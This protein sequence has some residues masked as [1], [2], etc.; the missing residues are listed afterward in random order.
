MSKVIKII[1]IIFS[2]FTLAACGGS[3]SSNSEPPAPTPTYTLSLTAGEGGSVSDNAGTYEEGTAVTIQATAD[4]GF[5]FIGW[6][7]SS[8]VTTNPLT[9]TVNGDTS[10]TANFARQFA[11]A[12]ATNT[13]GTVTGFDA[14]VAVDG[15]EITLTAT[16][17]EGYRFLR[18]EGSVDT[19]NSTN[20]PLTVTVSADTNLS[21]VFAQEF[22]VALT[23]Q[24]GGTVSG[25]NDTSALTGESITV[26][27]TPETG[28]RFTGWSGTVTSTDNPLAVTVSEDV[29]LTAN[30]VQTFAL[31]VSS[32]AGGSVD[33]LSDRYDVGSS[34]TL[35]A[36][37]DMDYRFDGWT[38]DVTSSENPLTVTVDQNLSVNA[39]FLEGLLGQAGR[40]IEPITQI[41]VAVFIITFPDT[42]DSKLAEFP[43]LTEM[44]TLL[45]DPQGNIV[46]YLDSISYGQF[47]LDF[48]VLGSFEYSENLLDGST[49][50]N[51]DD[52]R[53]MTSIEVAGFEP[54]AYDI[55]YYLLYSDVANLGANA[56][57]GNLANPLVINQQNVVKPSIVG[58]YWINQCYASRATD[59]GFPVSNAATATENYLIQLP[60]NDIEGQV[61]Y[62]MTQFERTT[63][64]EV[65]HAMGLGTHAYSSTNGAST[66]FEPEVADNGTFLNRD[67]GNK[68]DIM[69]TAEY[70]VSLNAGFRDFFGWLQNRKLKVAAP[71]THTVTL[72]PLNSTSGLTAVEVRIPNDF[73]L[74]DEFIANMVNYKNNGL[75]IEVRSTTDIYDVIDESQLSSAGS[76]L[77]INLTDGLTTRLIDAS[78]SANITTSYGQVAADLRDVTLQPGMSFVDASGKITIDNV[79]DNGDGS[80]TFDVTLTD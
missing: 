15:E 45:N 28:Y 8:T 36:T 66:Y 68:F 14:D 1:T 41:N 73:A 27:A 33:T 67:Y 5:V 51:K 63:I 32:G 4:T 18:W 10:L 69:G 48:D 44:N 26:T 72:R 12:L 70:G 80:F 40:E 64:H 53:G 50:L 37:P 23:A 47:K 75:F 3:S 61:S 74:G 38:G 60:V 46:Q 29:A 22:T 65:F 77:M 7:G 2:V 39:N 79:I 52:I 54:E 62:P 59:C 35:T 6:T 55:I 49:L 43:T 11:V 57:N 34:V 24:T 42:P 9:F 13:G 30:F 20:N 76:G 71:G 78:P 21:A 56:Q 25:F 17:E 58:T 31:N 16:P 19:A